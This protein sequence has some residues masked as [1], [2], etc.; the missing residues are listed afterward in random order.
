[1][2]AFLAGRKPNFQQFRMRD[3]RELAKYVDGF[4]RDLNTPPVMRKKKK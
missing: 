3:K 4:N 1:M 2:E